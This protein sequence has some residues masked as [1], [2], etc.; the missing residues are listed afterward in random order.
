MSNVDKFYTLLFPASLKNV[1]RFSAHPRLSDAPLLRGGKSSKDR[2]T[3]FPTPNLYY[4]LRDY[5]VI[6]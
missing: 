6:I 4:K 3:K 1:P 2:I 5:Y